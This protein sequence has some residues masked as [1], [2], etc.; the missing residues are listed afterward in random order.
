MN[1]ESRTVCLLNPAAGSE[2][3]NEVLLER[4][5]GEDGVEVL[6]GEE[7]GDLGRMAGE[8]AA[9]GAATVVVAGGDGT[10]NEVVAGARP[11]LD[12]TTFV[13]LPEGTGN[14]FARTLGLPLDPV[15]VVDAFLAGRLSPRPVDLVTYECDGAA[16]S[17]VNGSVGGFGAKVAELMDSGLKAFLGRLAYPVTAGSALS[18]LTEHH[19]LVD[20]DGEEFGVVAWNLYVTN[21]R[22]VGG[23]FEVSPDASPFDGLLDL[24]ILPVINREL[25]VDRAREFLEDP[26][27][28]GASLLLRRQ[29]R[30]IRIEADPPMPLNRDGDPAGRTPVVF[31]AAPGAL[32]FLL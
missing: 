19:L 12:R 22:T 30:R 16:G 17:F 24:A 10:L 15:A 28:E 21:G 9:A 1:R 8:V 4:L 3:A 32:R 7:P 13:L 18:E 27:G 11:H 25:L 6:R 26:L 31:E 20:A 23:G 2:R 5:D 29:A 14:D